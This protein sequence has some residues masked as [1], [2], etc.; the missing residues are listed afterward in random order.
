VFTGGQ[1]P[2]TENAMHL[3]KI[4][5]SYHDGSK[6]KGAKVVLGFTG[7]LGGMTKAAYTDAYGVALVEHASTGNADVYVS[8]NKVGSLRAPGQTVVFI[9]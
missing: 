2:H 8:G 3:S 1:G 5:V 7:M 4:H 9:S 6:P